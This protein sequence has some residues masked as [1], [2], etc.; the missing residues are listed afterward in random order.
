MSLTPVQISPAGAFGGHLTATTTLNGVTAGNTILALMLHGDRSGSSPTITVADGQGTYLVDVTAGFGGVTR[1]SAV[2][3][4]NA[5]AGTHT[6]VATANSGT[7][8]QSNGWL[9]ALEVPPA[10]FDQGNSN[11]SGGGTTAAAVAA[12]AGLAGAG[13]LALAG[14]YF[15]N[16]SV[17]GGTFPPTGGPGTYTEI[18]AHGS[19][20]AE[21]A[22]QVL[23]TAA[24]VGANWGTFTTSSKWAG[25]VAVY[26]PV[27]A[28]VPIAP[29]SLGGMVVQVCQ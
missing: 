27:S 28:F 19:N 3:L 8:A 22:Y 11:G 6:L 4:A 23:S 21:A 16:M 29:L 24:G 9:V 5:T 20:Q 1:A 7:A 25:V 12:T 2:R 26:Q 18:A 13:E 15:D 14:L 10:L 17:G